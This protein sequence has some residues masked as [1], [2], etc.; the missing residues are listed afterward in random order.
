MSYV[1]HLVLEKQFD[2][3]KAALAAAR[4]ALPADR[5]NLALAQCY[6][7]L[8]ETTKADGRMQ[9]A[10]QSPACDLATIRGAIDLCIN[11][12][13]FDQVEPLLNKLLAP[14]MASTP[15]VR[16]WANRTRSLAR[17]STGR[18]AEMDQALALI[19]LN[20]KANPASLPDQRLKAVL[21]ALQTSRRGD[22]IKLLEPLEESNQLGS[23]EQFIL[24]Q[25]YLS[26][27]LVSKYRSQMKKLLESGVKNPRHLVHFVEFLLDRR[28]LD[29][30]EVW[31]AEA[32]R[33]SP[34][35]ARL[36]R[37]KLAA[38]RCRQGRYDEAE[39]LFRQIL[40]S[41]P[42]NVE[43]L[44]NLAWELALREPGEPREALRLIDRA[45]EKR[46]RIST[47]V[48][49]RAV[50]LIRLG[51]PGRAVQELSAART[52]D[53]RNVSLALHLAW[54]LQEAGQ[55]LEAMKVFQLAQELGLKP[56]ARHPLERG[57][58]DRL[59]GQLGK[60]Q[61]SPSNRS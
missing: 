5:A 60:D 24:A 3:A 27:G 45:I 29:Q 59:L 48:D 40:D 10:L 53:P 42:E 39:T 2:Q 4:R 1:Q 8:G 20:L 37:P 18:L 30:A 25:T 58:I 15:D 17:L 32:I 26:E 55:A 11:Q 47:F 38:I 54:A 6:A 28:E 61:S 49:T 16:A 33:K 7:M 52:A 12:G 43:T 23:N 44:N 46:G 19:E 56:E 21:L 50:V 57:L 34:S 22:A 9:A 51:E 13:R 41:D 36:L 14:A 31:I 35:A